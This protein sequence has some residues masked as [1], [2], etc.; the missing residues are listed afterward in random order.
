MGRNNWFVS[1]ISTAA[2]V[3]CSKTAGAG[4]SSKK[5]RLLGCSV[6]MGSSI[7]GSTLAVSL[8]IGGSTTPLFLSSPEGSQAFEGLGISST[9]FAL[10]SPTTA[11]DG[12]LGALWGDY[13]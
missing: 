4:Y 8:H 10:E 7:A 12:I 6:Q 13:K 5:L 11:V 9:Y 2:E 1:A 3:I